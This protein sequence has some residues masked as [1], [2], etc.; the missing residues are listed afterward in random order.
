MKISDVVLEFLQKDVGWDY[1]QLDN[2]CFEAFVPG[3]NCIIQLIWIP[4]DD[5]KQLR[6]V[7]NLPHYV[8]QNSRLIV[9]EFLNRVNYLLRVGNFEMNYDNGEVR[10]RMFIDAEDMPLSTKLV[11]RTTIYSLWMLDRYYVKILDIHCGNS[12][13]QDVIEKIKREEVG[14]SSS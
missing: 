14:E 8:P 11:K 13:P 9:G 12:T 2:N 10:F 7:G 3:D 6:I 4:Y 1:N 5:D